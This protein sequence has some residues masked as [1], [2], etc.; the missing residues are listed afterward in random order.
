MAAV[1]HKRS[2]DWWERRGIIPELQWTPLQGPIVILR[3]EHKT[4]SEIVKKYKDFIPYETNLT[5]C[6]LALGKGCAYWNHFNY[7]PTQSYLSRRDSELLSKTIQL[8]DEANIPLDVAA[9]T[10]E[11]F[12]LK[13]TRLCMGRALLIQMNCEKLAG[14]L[15]A[16]AKEPPSNSW[17]TTF[18][19]LHRLS[20]RNSRTICIDRILGCRKEII[21]DFF[22]RNKEILEA[23]P[24]QLTYFADETMLNGMK[25]VRVV[26]PENERRSFDVEHEFPHITAMCCN[27]A[28]GHALRPF[29]LL[30]KLKTPTPDIRC[31]S[32]SRDVFIVANNSAWMTIHAF[33]I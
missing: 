33:C 10:D 6:I 11:A 5:A 21:R 12:K 22:T 7:E 16:D 14:Q 28:V 24:P 3:L 4:Y 32:E 8:H 30:P 1:F 13:I 17:V 23:T 20:I 27:N 31:L 2:D 9:V 25:C 15:L 19:H 26:V 29:V 18:V